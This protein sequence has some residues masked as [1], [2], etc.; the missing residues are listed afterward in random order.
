MFVDLSGFTSLAEAM[1]DET[2][3]RVLARFG[4]IVRDA[5]GRFDGS[6][7]KQIG[8]AF[9]LVFPEARSA[10]A[11]ALDVER[12]TAVEPQFPAVRTGIHW[13]QV[14]YRE[15]DYFGTTVNLASRAE[16][17]ARAGEIVVTEDVVTRTKDAALRDAGWTSTPEEATPKGFP[18]PV[19]IVRWSRG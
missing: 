17:L 8:D 19:R 16:H 13:G 3:V 18:R 6:V 4:H 12:Q 15:G 5:T 14:L 1:G 9:M 7:V 2:S 10:V 11:C